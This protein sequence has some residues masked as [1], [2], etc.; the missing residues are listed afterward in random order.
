MPPL[1]RKYLLGLAGLT[2]I[3]FTL[4]FPPFPTGVLAVAAF[5]PLLLMT[6]S[7]SS[8]GRFFRYAYFMFFLVSA[9]TLYW[10]GGFT[11]LRDPYLMI[12]GGALLLWQPFFLTLLASVYY[13][14]RKRVPLGIALTAFPFVWVTGEWLYALGEF[15][16]PWLTI[17]NTQTYALEKIQ[18]IEWTGVYGLSL[19]LLVMNVLLFYLFYSVP[20][21][22]V[23]K[24]MLFAGLVMTF[25]IAPNVYTAV[26]PYT[27]SRQDGIGIGIV[28]PNIDPWDKWEGANTFSGRWQQ[29]NAFLDVI[30]REMNDSLDIAVLPESAILLNLPAFP[31]HRSEFL[32][33]VESLGVSVLSGYARFEYYEEGKAPVSSNTVKATGQR[34]DS[35]NSIFFAQPGRTEFQ[36]YS[37]MRLVPFAE[38][39]PY[40]EDVPFLIEPLRWGVGISNWGMGKDSTVFRH[41][42]SGHRFLAMVCY[43]SIFP[44]FVA[45]FVAGGA[46]FLVFITNDSWWGNTSGARQHQQYAVL[47][48]VENRRWVA[49]CANGGISSFIDPSGTLYDVTAMYEPA[50]IQRTI[51]PQSYNTFY[52]LHGDWIARISASMTLLFA[53]F[54]MGYPLISKKK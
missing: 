46:E 53:C 34:W 44:E 14:I 15:A 1:Q 36:S 25:Y 10:V 30:R 32:Q 35:F 6:E 20:A 26:A 40:A 41:E 16:F 39:I 27:P 43:E 17:G 21:T 52:S 47:R 33:R 11:H 38:R 28:Q 48:A 31:Q 50:Y 49:R 9:G 18:F 29:T 7:V 54:S 51:F 19:W 42:S 12:A 22:A 2:G 23:R 37:K 24:K 5:I 45:S 13:G 4:S 3:L 8:F